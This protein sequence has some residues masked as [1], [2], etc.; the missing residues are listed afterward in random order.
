MQAADRRAFLKGLLD[1]FLSQSKEKGYIVFEVSSRPSEYVQ[2]QVHS[3]R[4]YG[5]VGSRQW[6][7]PEEP[8]PAAA[9]QA[10]ALLGFTG[11]GPEKNYS[12]DGLACSAAE[13]A[14]LADRL[15]KAAYDV[16][17]EFSPVVRE[18]NLNDITLPRAEPF[19]RD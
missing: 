17:D 9:V 15:F 16:D 1:T 18:M 13:L 4:I 12:K 11:G 6:A 7:E 5:E 19:T 10:L 3:G 8:L 2:F 14:D